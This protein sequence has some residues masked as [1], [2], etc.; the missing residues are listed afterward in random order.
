MSLIEPS[1]PM[2]MF[3]DVSQNWVVGITDYGISYV[4]HY[5]SFIGMRPSKLGNFKSFIFVETRS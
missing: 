2:L 3:S 5:F 4:I 1:F